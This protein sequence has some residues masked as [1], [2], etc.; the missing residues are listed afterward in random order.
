MK[1]ITISLCGELPNH[2]ETD[3][4]IKIRN[5]GQQQNHLALLCTVSFMEPRL[6]TEFT[7]TAKDY[8][9]PKLTN[10]LFYL[11]FLINMNNQ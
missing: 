3:R 1:K 11:F 2:K 7:V 4:C 5:W 10:F 9:I 8:L 6:H